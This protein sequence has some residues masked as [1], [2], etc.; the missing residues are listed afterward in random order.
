MILFWTNSL[1]VLE[2]GIDRPLDKEIHVSLKYKIG[3]QN[4][5]FP[6]EIYIYIQFL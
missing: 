4:D 2:F 3:V 1:N 6:R 5:S